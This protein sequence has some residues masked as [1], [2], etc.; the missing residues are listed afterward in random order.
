[1][2]RKLESSVLNCLKEFRAEFLREICILKDSLGNI[3]Q[4]LDGN[5]I[6]NLEEEVNIEHKPEVAIINELSRIS[7]EGEINHVKQ[8]ER[9]IDE[10][11]IQENDWK[12]LKFTIKRWSS[13]SDV[14]R[15]EIKNQFTPLQIEAETLV[16]LEPEPEVNSFLSAKDANLSKKIQNDPK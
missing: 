9:T 14:F 4:K 3:T 10:I 11:Y 6:L 13:E 1:M 7:G 12:K 8:E 5:V 16:K 2:S 15:L